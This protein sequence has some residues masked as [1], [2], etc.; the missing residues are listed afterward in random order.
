MALPDTTRPTLLEARRELSISIRASEEWQP[1]YKKHPATFKAL[2]LHEAQLEE[3]VAE[4]LAGLAERAPNYI[5][6][7]LIPEPVQVTAASSPLANKDDAVWEGEALD[8]T[9]AVI[10]AIT[11]L[12]ATGGQYGELE[13]GI[14]LGITSLSESVL[15]AAREQTATLVSQVTETNRKLIREAIKQSIARG[16]DVDGTIARI[17]KVINNPVRAEMIAQTESVNAYQA[18][19]KNFATETGAKQKIW[20]ALAGACKVCAPV[21]GE[22]VGIDELFSNG[23]AIPSAHPRCRCGV[24]YEY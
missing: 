21:D 3:S 12:A 2:L 10:E 15:V 22:K 5:D 8:L 4:Y 18:G 20:E 23:K 1:S 7:S 24:Y 13:Y 16:E 14:D 19:L 11:L 9:K 17:K 6:W